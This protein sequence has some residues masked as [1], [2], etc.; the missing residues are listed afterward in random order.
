MAKKKKINPAGILFLAAIAVLIIAL[1]AVIIVL[2]VTCG[3]N[4]NEVVEEQPSSSADPITTNDP[5]TEQTT[6]DISG[7]LNPG[8]TDDPDIGTG[9]ASPGTTDG[10]G[11]GTEGGEDIVINTPAAGT[12]S[13]PDPNSSIYTEP[14]REMRNNAKQ[15]H[16]KKDGVRMRKGP[17]TSHEV[18]IESIPVGTSVT[19]YVEQDGWYF[20]KCDSKYGYI[21]S[22]MLGTGEWQDPD[23]PSD[24]IEGVVGGNS[25][26]ALRKEP[27]RGAT[28]IAD[29]EKGTKLYIFHKVKDSDG[30]WWYYVQIVGTK[31][32]GYIFGEL[33]DPKGSVPAKD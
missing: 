24:A 28:C 5:I 8:S 14:T 3:G 17:G 12:E 32:K 15:G 18:I 2:C 29:Y 30:D 21:R 11:N 22:D 26:A 9:T 16:V 25:I 1:V 23:K 4:E 19:L 20:L 27:K 10:T 33:V 31:T 13:T 6:P 7:L